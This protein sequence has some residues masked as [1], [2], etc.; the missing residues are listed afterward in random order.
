MRRA[1]LAA[2]VAAFVFPAAAS[3]QL[4]GYDG[5]FGSG[6]PGSGGVF[7]DPAGIATDLAGRVYVAD[8]AKGRI[9]VFDSG[10]EGNKFLRTIGDGLLKQPVG[11]FVDLRNRIFVADAGVDQVLE[12]DT[13]NSGAPF[14]RNWG[15]SGTELGKMSGPRSV[16]TGLTGLAFDA[17]AA[18]A[19]VQWFAP[20]EGQMV[21]VSAFGTADP[22]TF[23]NPEGI[24][25]DNDANQIYVTNN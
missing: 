22:P 16:V 5:S 1:L 3:A 9:E 12:F 17:E 2:L 24:A 20:K 11:V 14:M 18:N 13:F 19:R 8:T 6:A 10:E 21:S 7:G 25:I 15:G 4:F 23:D